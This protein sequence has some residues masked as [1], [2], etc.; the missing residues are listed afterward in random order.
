MF[1]PSE[2]TSGRMGPGYHTP[3]NVAAS[4]EKLRRIASL[5]EP[6]VIVGQGE[7]AAALAAEAPKATL[8]DPAEIDETT[9]FQ[10]RGRRHRLA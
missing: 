10:G 6:D 2:P 9:Q 5:L 3:L 1:P 8:L 7:L 4:V